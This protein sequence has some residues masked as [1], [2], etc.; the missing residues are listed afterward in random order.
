MD[1][2]DA[3]ETIS[4]KLARLLS[5]LTGSDCSTEQLTHLE[6]IVEAAAVLAMDV[7]KQRALY[8]V[9]MPTGLRFDRMYMEDVGTQEDSSVVSGKGTVRMVIFPFVTKWGVEAG[10]GYESFVT[11]SKTKVLVQ[12]Q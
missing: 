4:H 5:S 11:I 9:E 12:Y 8:K 10:I 2:A 6:Q 3:V 1:R 7:A